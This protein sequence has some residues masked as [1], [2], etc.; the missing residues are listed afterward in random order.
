MDDMKRKKRNGE[1]TLGD[2]VESIQQLDAR[3]QRVGDDLGARIDRL[4]DRVNRR[5]DGV[6]QLIGGHH[7]DLDRRVTALEKSV[8]V[9]KKTA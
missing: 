8:A 7:R 6:L 2:V 9:L 1:T 4:D 3:L 5:L